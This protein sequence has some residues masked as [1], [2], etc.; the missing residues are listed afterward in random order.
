MWNRGDRMKRRLIPAMAVLFGAA[1]TPINSFRADQRIVGSQVRESAARFGHPR[2]RSIWFPGRNVHV[3]GNGSPPCH[4]DR[5]VLARH[6]RSFL[7]GLEAAYGR[8]Q[9]SK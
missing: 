8:S 1:A 3:R 2:S 7:Y 9:G 6:A 4:A 5:S